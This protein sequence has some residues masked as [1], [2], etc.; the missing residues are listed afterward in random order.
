M[1]AG[2]LLCTAWYYTIVAGFYV[3]YCPTLYIMFL[4]QRWYRK[5]VDVLFAL[6]ELYPVA[7]FQ[8]FCNTE[9]HHYGDYVNPDEKTIMVINHRTRIDWNYVWIGLY[10]AMQ[11]PNTEVCSCKENKLTVERQNRDFLDSLSG[12]KSKIKFVLKDELKTVPGLGWVM[13]LNY[14]LYIKRSWQEDQ[15][16]LT[17]FVDYYKKMGTS[18]RLILFPEG[19]DLSEQNKRRSE[20]YATA[21]NLPIYNFVMH[22]RTTGWAELCARLRGAG[23]ASVYDVTVQYDAPAQTEIDLLRGRWPSN[24]H[25]YFKR[26]PIEQLPGEEVD[27][28]AWLNQRWREKESSLQR[29]HTEGIFVD[30]STGKI[31]IQRAPRSLCVAKI[32]FIFWSMVDIMFTFAMFNSVV[33]QFW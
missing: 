24:V 30:A 6:W 9:L 16:N 26:Y 4:N 14:F 5:V 19:T 20:K 32:G 31:P 8:C 23:L 12:G 11:D 33:F 15:L 29:F 21:N 13:Q 2:L 1:A 25:F 10:H 3:L 28:R 27:L 7:L 22:P 18:F 17:Q